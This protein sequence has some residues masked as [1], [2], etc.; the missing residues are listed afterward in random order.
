MSLYRIE[1]EG[2]SGLAACDVVYADS[3]VALERAWDAGLPREA[4]VRTTAPGMLI[5]PVGN[6]VQADRHMSAKAIW[7]L[8]AAFTAL[9]R[10]CQGAFGDDDIDLIAARYATLEFQNPAYKAALLE[11]DDFTHP[12][13]VI[14][15]SSDDAD[16]DRM[17]RSPLALLLAGNPDLTV[18]S[19]P[20]DSLPRDDD[21]RAP[22][23]TLKQR[24]QFSGLETL[25]Y[26]AVERLS[27]RWNLTGPRGRTIILRENEL[28]KE[29]AWAMI[30]R[31][32]LP[33]TV[34]M[35]KPGEHVEDAGERDTLEAEFLPIVGPMI[36]KHLA[37]HIRA[38]PA[39][40]V[41]AGLFSKGL[42]SRVARYRRSLPDWEARLKNVIRPG[43]TA[44]LTNWLND[45]EAIGLK[46]V[47]ESTSVPMVFF[48]HGVTNEINWRMR[49]Y[50]A[51]YGT[52]LCD[53]EC[54]F[55]QTG[56]DYAIK[57]RFRRGRA[58]AT[59]FPKDYYRGMRRKGAA[60]GEEPPVWYICTAFYV[61]NHG[62]LEGV[63]DWQKCGFERAI[64]QKVLDRCDH[65]ITFKPYPG[66]RYEDP[67]PI[68]T[69]V[70]ESA[71]IVMHRSRLD[72][73]YVVRHARVLISSRS[74]STPSWCLAT[75][76]PLIHI[77]IP[78]QEPLDGPARKAFEDGVFLFDAGDPDFHEKL[79]SFLN[80][81]LAEI[82][83]L[84]ADKAEA[85][86][87]LMTTF[88]S[89]FDP[90]HTGRSAGSRA[91]DEVIREI[92]SRAK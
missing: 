43:R 13:C 8:D 39:L 19:V 21:P 72:L 34:A 7:A 33:V 74:F 75:G 9:H 66:R 1:R 55:N 53:L 38:R 29:T 82:E 12:V 64:V 85:R 18:L 51:Q 27:T 56:A 91:A 84:W 28:S 24:L 30:L 63:T 71:N 5:D 15:L 80:Q 20:I 44:V 48:Q 42:A 50:E 60:S 16:L 46:R 92:R 35:P 90:E 2:A 69:A 67:D 23:P 14:E 70:E 36:E 83:R 62:Q 47:M 37:S 32:Y 81:P 49:E 4:Q 17:T 54:G 59:G 52:S 41:L 65:R 57:N 68:E 25:V 26:R 45:P 76:L 10:D 31:G 87:H 88:M 40:D 6:T 79:L 61:S 86:A 77:D 73:R 89:A 3:S 22:S 58:V 78:D 11:E